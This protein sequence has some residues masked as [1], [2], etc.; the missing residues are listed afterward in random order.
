MALTMTIGPSGAT[1]GNYLPY[2]DMTSIVIEDSI[3]VAA[4]SF[5]FTL[6]IYNHEINTPLEGYE[7]IFKDGSTIEFAGIIVSITREFGP[8]FNVML[9]HCVCKD[10]VYLLNRRF[11][12]KTY[13]SQAAGQTIKDIL[14]DLESD[15][16]SDIH[17]AF[18]KDN[19]TNIDD[20][21]T[22]AAQTYDKLI[23]TQVFD[24]IA[25]A[26]GMRWWLGFDKQIYFK[27]ITDVGA[28]SS[29]LSLNIL[30]IDT[31]TDSYYDYQ[32]EGNI[33]DIGTFLVLRGVR[34][35]STAN[36]VDTFDGSAGQDHAGNTNKI[37]P[38]SRTPFTL[39]DL[40]SVTKSTGGGGDIEQ[41]LNAEDID[42]SP[43]GGEGGATDVYR[44]IRN[45][46]S[47]VRFS[48]ANTVLDADTIKITYRYSILEDFEGPEIDGINEMSI[49]TGGDGVHQFI[50]SQTSG[51]AIVDLNGYDAI[52]SM[53]LLR[54]S[55][56]QRRGSFKSRLKGWSA[57]DTFQRIWNRETLNDDMYVVSVTK[58][59]L[60]PADSPSDNVIES[61]IVF[62]N[63]PYGF[64]V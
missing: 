5:E 36:M 34:I 2:V 60:T 6:V 59:I 56:I 39:A 37:F 18:F 28:L 41:T 47:Y 49:R 45:E 1:T 51:L 21:P 63:F 29:P 30:T 48:N 57:G 13:S 40:T 44:R 38:L 8:D 50:Y 32:E 15:S 35:K 10:Y 54:K 53:L 16:D 42:G 46:G 7:V 17:Y 14:T 58:R 52:E 61:A 3:E 4:D 22:L 24:T 9:Y 12:N 23:P 31:D 19:I 62:S 25:Q 20:G 43:P 27:S 55:I 64:D 33:E 26:T 11:V